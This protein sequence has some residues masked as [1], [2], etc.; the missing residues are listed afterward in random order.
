MLTGTRADAGMGEAPV[1]G[2]AWDAVAEGGD[3]GRMVWVYV[4]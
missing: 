2:Y 3:L 1:D 4:V